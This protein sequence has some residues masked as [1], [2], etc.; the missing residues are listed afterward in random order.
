MHSE[1]SGPHT[2]SGGSAV[3]A[4]DSGSW[5]SRSE[6][7]KPTG[8][9]Q[10]LLA[11]A[12]RTVLL[13]LA[14]ALSGA[15]Q[16]LSPGKAFHNFI[17]DSWSVEQGLPHIAAI[18]VAQDAE[19]YIWVGTPNGLA[20]FDGV[21]F[22]SY[23]AATT[24]GLPGDVVDALQLDA[25][26]RLWIGTNRGLAWYRGGVF[27]A[28]PNA[29]AA[30]AASTDILN[31]LVSADGKLLLATRGGLSRLVDGQLA[32]DPTIAGPVLALLEAEGEQWLGGAGGVYRLQ[33]GTPRF[34]AL[35]GLLKHEPV[36]HLAVSDGVLWAGT[37]SGLYRRQNAG[38]QR[39]GER[40]PLARAAIG[41]MYADKDGDLWVGTDSG[42]SRLREGKIVEQIDNDR[43]GTRWDYLTGF[44]DRE[45]NLWFGSRTRG[46]TRLWSGLT[47]RYSIEEG[48][49][50]PQVWALERD[51]GGRVWVGTD[52]GLSLLVDGHYTQPVPARALPD[53]T[54]FSL[55]VEGEDLWVGTLKGVV[56]LRRGQP[57]PLPAL[58]PLDGLRINGMLRDRARRLW[59][60]T[61]NGLFRY[62]G[63]ALTR[64]GKA[65]GLRDT[66]VRVLYQTRDG[67][68]LL[69]TQSGLGE[70]S[71]DAVVMLGGDHGLPDDIDVTAIHELPDRRLVVGAATELLYVAEGDRWTGFGHAQGLPPNTPFRLFDD[72]RG[73]LW[74]AGLRGLYR[75]PL[76]DLRR[77]PDGKP[78]AVRAEIYGNE[79]AVRST[80]PRAECCNGTGNSKG[81]MDRGAMWLPTRDGVL[82]VPTETLASNRVPPTVRIEAVNAGNGWIGVDRFVKTRLPARIRDLSF[83]FSA[84]SF[85]DP[86][87]VQL[88]YRLRGYDADWR[89]LKDPQSRHA[90]YTN[91]PPGDYVFEVRGANNAGIWSQA[92]A[93]VQFAIK[94]RL[95]ETTW[96]YVLAGLLLALIAF[97]A[98]RWQLRALDHRR[99]VLE[100]IVA[101]R[102]DA[103]A[104]AN[105]QLEKASYT[106]PLTGL[107]NRRYL[108]NQLPQ[109][110]AFYRR[111][112]KGSYQA[113][114]ILLFLLVDI[115][116]FK[117]INDSHGHGGG[118]MVLQQFSSL[119]GELVRVGDYVTRW[120]GE[121]FLIVSRPLSRD[122]A[123]SYASRICTV[124]SAHPFDAGGP[125]P[126]QLSCSIG[127]AEYPLQTTP[128]SLDWQDLVEIADRALYH[129]KENGRNGWAAFLFTPTTPF[130][131]LIQRFKR[132]RGSLLAEGG[133]RLITSRD[134][135]PPDSQV[136]AVEFKARS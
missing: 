78:Q 120:G 21:R 15:A 19:G 89:P 99:A 94:P 72:A 62:D 30:P 74:V 2:V 95:H 80:G 57:E 125:E 126:L 27:T 90:D 48:L 112:A 70:W 131:S 92:P 55:L 49:H 17:R 11:A 24:P 71:R 52:E 82:V 102:T 32:A 7:L 64:Y 28:V 25:E 132:D 10:N 121:E 40:T 117:R 8:S 84:L 73:Y 127:F 35:P 46:L 63:G 68:L 130:P 113:D 39:Y 4:A 109:D 115:D 50:S 88:Q 129:V 77:G 123:V 23:L 87:A 33:A 134:P 37:G 105:Q 86:N 104:L 41:L 13:S 76:D 119:L 26:G 124:V 36:L 22:T 103:L 107:R 91:L 45:N 38:W 118:D 53:P 69:G 20:R 108:L 31:I 47:N 12:L 65:E 106:D 14:I 114:H 29:Q 60:A 66:S 128:P 1:T 79:F 97:A 96:F 67:R 111:N 116:H 44:E 122:H 43:M 110:L 136:V 5:S 83:K 93:S 18:A 100:S 133:L 81:F 101:Q 51:A 9:G 75:L 34:E 58:K 59:F 54:V 85:Q 3:R 135:L 61:S 6:F 16:A 98:H 56:L 42:L